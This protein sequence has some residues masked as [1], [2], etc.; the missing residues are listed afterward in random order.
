MLLL[1]NLFGNIN[2]LSAERLLT[3]AKI[4][5]IISLMGATS[6]ITWNL[7]QRDMDKERVH[8]IQQQLDTERATTATWLARVDEAT[9]IASKAAE[10]DRKLD[11]QV[12]AILKEHKNAPPLPADCVLDT[13]GL[14]SLQAAR[15]A[16]IATANPSATSKPNN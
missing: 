13:S 11:I 3:I 8:A 5:A 14:L 6:Y 1:S 12:S 16:A 2:W 9:K 15:A 10:V 7:A 4:A